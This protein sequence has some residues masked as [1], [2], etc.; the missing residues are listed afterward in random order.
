M[1]KELKGDLI[2]ILTYFKNGL[3]DVKEGCDGE[4]Q[5]MLK[6]LNSALKRVKNNVVLAD[7]IVPKGTL[8]CTYCLGTGGRVIY[9]NY[10]KCKECDGSG[11][12]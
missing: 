6:E 8:V 10:L 7:V 11:A 3:E 9:D 2:Y 5:P 4:D 12:N 1:D